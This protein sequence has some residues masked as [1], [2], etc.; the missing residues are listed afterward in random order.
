MRK[1]ITSCLLLLGA[2][3]IVLQSCRTDEATTTEE[4]AQKEKITFFEHFEQGKPLSKNSSLNYA[5]PF[6]QS[7]GAYF[8]KYPEKKTEL[9]NKHGRIDLK[10]SSQDIS[11]DEGDGRK[12][13]FFPILKDGKVTAVIAGVVNAKRDYL[14]FDVYNSGH[15]DVFYLLNKFQQY[16]NAKTLQK[17]GNDPHEIEGIIITVIRPVKLTQYDG[18]SGN[19]GLGS[20]GHDMGGGNEDFGGGNGPGTSQNPNNTN[21][22]EKA[23]TE[24]DKA[25][26]LLETAAI[27]NQKTELTKTLGTD[28]NEKSFSF[29]KDS[30]G[31][32]KVKAI[33][34]GTNGNSVGVVATNN[35]ISLEGG[36]HTHTS[37]LYNS[38]SAGDFYA[39]QQANTANPNFNYFYVFGAGNSAYALT[40]TNPSAFAGLSTNF[41][42]AT[43]FDTSTGSWNINSNIGADFEFAF[44]QFSANG[45]SE[46]EA[47]ENA[48]AMIMSKYDMGIS[49][50]KKDVSGAFKSIFV[51]EKLISVN[52]AGV[53]VS[54][55]TYE[56]TTDCNLQ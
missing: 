36:I 10:V 52:L 14:Y 35:T 17:G 25:K 27:S 13:L 32:Y 29:G 37:N 46:D 44:N 45:I 40:I 6:G 2:L 5:I 54:I 49:L 19:G 28:T 41:P 1:K 53:V 48:T 34:A 24:N 39:F 8:Q 50:S 3:S 55:K 16:Y 18:W 47:F 26:T 22:C 23:Q 43:Y 30:N 38:F 15:A 31:N 12:L 21:P 56:K 20:G 4:Q 11:G 7:I 33:I 9:E 51:K 42:M